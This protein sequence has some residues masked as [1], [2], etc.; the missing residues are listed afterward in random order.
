MDTLIGLIFLGVVGYYVY[1]KLTKPAVVEE[2]V[3]EVKKEPE[4]V[5][6]A[7]VPVVEEV[8]APVV[9]NAKEEVKANIDTKTEEAF[10]KAMVEEATKVET[11]VVE[12]AKEVA[13]ELVKEVDQ[14]I[15]EIKV[16]ELRVVK[17]GRKKKVK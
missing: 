4:I 6:V 9:D 1:K 10:V 12:N 17:K 3:E 8:P 2:V 11:V 5:V 16:Q 15:E 7:P 14:V 13:A